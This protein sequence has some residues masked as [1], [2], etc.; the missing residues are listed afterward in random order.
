MVITI[1]SVLF[2]SAEQN[3]FDV[4]NNKKIKS[5]YKNFV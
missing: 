5:I 3:Y 4:Q 2:G 1:K